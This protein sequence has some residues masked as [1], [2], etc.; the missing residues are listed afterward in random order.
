MNFARLIVLT[1]VVGMAS[2]VLAQRS[3]SKNPVVDLSGSN[4]AIVNKWNQR[5][6]DIWCGA[7]KAARDRGAAWTDRLYI[8]GY[9]DA[10]ASQ[11]GAVT[12]SYTFR[13]TQ[14]Q[15]AQ[16]KSGRSSIRGIGNNMTINSANRRCVRELDFF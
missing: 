3:T 10:Q 14:E 2:P 1:A 12:V 4:F 5:D 7:A 15:L 16:A 6:D 9:E 11:Y 8:I 13:P